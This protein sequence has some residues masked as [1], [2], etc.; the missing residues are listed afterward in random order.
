MF[1]TYF[2]LH[3]CDS[4]VPAREVHEQGELVGGLAKIKKYE[5]WVFSEVS[6]QLKYPK[7]ERK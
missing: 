3:H 1:H 5:K 6:N 7:Q 2:P 4:L